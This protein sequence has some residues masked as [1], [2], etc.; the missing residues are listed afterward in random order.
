MKKILIVEDDNKLRDELEIFLNNNGYKVDT[1]KTF[2]DTIND[3]LK[4]EPELLLLDINL[5]GIDGEFICKEVRKKS[6]I[7]IIIITS[8]DSEI[9]GLTWKKI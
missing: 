5:P 2:E 6:N 7:P 3:I 4:I 8:R 9:D 1:L